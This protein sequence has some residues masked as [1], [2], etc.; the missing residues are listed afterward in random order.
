MNIY[1]RTSIWLEFLFSLYQYF[2]HIS[3]AKKKHLLA[4][5]ILKYS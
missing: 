5:I 3:A 2:Q 4:F 1:K